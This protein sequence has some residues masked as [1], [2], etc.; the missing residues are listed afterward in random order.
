MGFAYLHRYSDRQYHCVQS[1]A[2]TRGTNAMPGISMCE[3]EMYAEEMVQA[4][5][6]GQTPWL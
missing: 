4:K 6:Q 1:R 2:H 5:I 3:E